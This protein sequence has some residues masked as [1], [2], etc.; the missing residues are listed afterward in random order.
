MT[1]DETQNKNFSP[2][3]SLVQLNTHIL[4]PVLFLITWMPNG[5]LVI[6]TL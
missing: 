3:E 4:V 5:F 1:T 6:R 2:A